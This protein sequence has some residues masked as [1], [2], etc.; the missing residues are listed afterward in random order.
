MHFTCFGSL[1][2][3][4]RAVQACQVWFRIAQ[5]TPLL[6]EMTKNLDD[7]CMLVKALA[8]VRKL[9]HVFKDHVLLEFC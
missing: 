5:S 8:N 1:L 3:N 2:P 4:G 9:L 7:M 6:L